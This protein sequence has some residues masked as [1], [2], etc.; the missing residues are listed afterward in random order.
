MFERIDFIGALRRGWRLAAALA[1][2]GF[3]VAILIPVSTPKVK[4]VDAKYHWRST[5]L[6]W[7]NDYYTR[8]A[9]CAMSGLGYQYG[10]LSALMTA[11]QTSFASG[12][13]TTGKAAT[14]ATKGS[15]VVQLTADGSSKSSAVRLADQFAV[16]VGQAVNKAYTAHVAALTAGSAGSPSRPPSRSRPG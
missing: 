8:A 1:V 15:S 11:N 13:K 12:A 2:V 9:A 5:V 3:V 16:A 4:G 7:A 14:K 6:V 10:P